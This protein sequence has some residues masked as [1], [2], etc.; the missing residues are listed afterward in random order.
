MCRAVGRPSKGRD[1]FSQ[2][3]KMFPIHLQD[4]IIGVHAVVIMNIVLNKTK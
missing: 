3:Q 1:A 2:K 4:M